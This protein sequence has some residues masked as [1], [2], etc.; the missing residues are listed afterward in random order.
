MPV[1]ELL[2][3]S[4]KKRSN[5]EKKVLTNREARAIVASV[6]RMTRTKRNR[7][8]RAENIRKER[9]P[10]KLNNEEMTKAPEMMWRHIKAQ[11][12]GVESIT[13]V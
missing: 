7:A 1:S 12:L 6:P 9:V 4:E 13:R 3:R 11:A 5:F 10:C 2:C 8:K